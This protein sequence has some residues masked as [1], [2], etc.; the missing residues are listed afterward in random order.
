MSAGSANDG[1]L[2]D[3]FYRF[4]E[5][6]DAGGEWALQELTRRKP[7]LKNPTPPDLEAIT[8][9]RGVGGAPRGR[10]GDSRAD[11]DGFP[12]RNVVP[13]IAARGLRLRRLDQPSQFLCFGSDARLTL[14][15]TLRSGAAFT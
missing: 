6:Y 8:V 9:E 5:L 12:R 2:A 13:R 15:R 3:G 11:G 10:R 4:K 7:I 14:L 1:L